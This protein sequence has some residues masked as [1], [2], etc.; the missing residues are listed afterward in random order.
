MGHTAVLDIES[1][2]VTLKIGRKEPKKTT[3]ILNI[4]TLEP[5]RER[6]LSSYITPPVIFSARCV[7]P[8]IPKENKNPY[9]GKMIL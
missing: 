7:F 8:C 2:S 3:F 1:S 9:F 5:I 6:I 4:F